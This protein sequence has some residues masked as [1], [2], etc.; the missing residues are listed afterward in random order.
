MS[1]TKLVNGKR[2]PLTADE[3]TAR[4]AEEAAY[5][6]VKDMMEWKR[7]ISETDSVIPRYVEDIIDALPKA[8]RDKINQETL[9]KYNKK[10]E[11]RNRKP[12]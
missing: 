7:E 3:L 8:T 6:A 1:L 11:V 5:E 9:A 10:K 12:K 2:V 4:R